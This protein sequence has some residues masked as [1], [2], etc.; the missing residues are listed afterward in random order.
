MIEFKHKR[1]T[2]VTQLAVNQLNFDAVTS[3]PFIEF[4]YND[5]K[6]PLS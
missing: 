4:H 6:L 2:L 3:I 5:F 1:G